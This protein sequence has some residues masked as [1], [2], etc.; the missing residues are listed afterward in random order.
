VRPTDPKVVFAIGISSPRFRV[1]FWPSC[2]R[3][4]AWPPTSSASR[5][6]G[7]DDRRRD[8]QVEVR[9]AHAARNRVQVEGRHADRRSAPTVPGVT[10][11]RPRARRSR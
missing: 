1:I 2:P 3:S 7:T 4:W 9:G 5:S 11:G 6:R 10:V 8:R